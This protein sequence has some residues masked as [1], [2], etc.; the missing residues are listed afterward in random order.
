MHHNAERR[1][2]Q[3]T[4]AATKLR[5]G[6]YQ[7][8]A[9]Y[10]GDTVY[11]GS[12]SAQ[13]T[14]TVMAELT[15]TGLSISTGTVKFGHEQSEDL[16]V[17]VKPAFGGTVA[18]KVTIKNRIHGPLHDHPGQRQGQL[19]P[20]R[21]HAPPR[22]IHPHRHLHRHQPLRRIHLPPETPTVTT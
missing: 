2:G 10:G 11:H 3:R 15:S 20:V 21:Q 7:L 18:G 9:S 6:T 17:T 4:P 16:T 19:H 22:H 1:H 14:V 13:H 12:T 8:T 5:P